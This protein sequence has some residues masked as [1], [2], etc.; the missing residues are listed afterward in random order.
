MISNNR[1]LTLPRDEYNVYHGLIG[2]NHAI[3][4]DLEKNKV[5]KY[6]GCSKLKIDGYIFNGLLWTD[7]ETKEQ[8]FLVKGLSDQEVQ[9]VLEVGAQHIKDAIDTEQYGCSLIHLPSFSYYSGIEGWKKI[10]TINA[11]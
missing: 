9:H 1:F 2:I 11:V 4:V 5:C 7:L 10:I 6:F 3:F 8:E